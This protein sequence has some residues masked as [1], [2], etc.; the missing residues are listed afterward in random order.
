MK[1]AVTAQGNTLNSPVDPHFGRAQYF[2]VVETGS[3]DFEVV[4]NEQN[5]NAPQGAGIQAGKTV[6]DLKADVLITGHCGPKAFRTL[7]SAGIA[8]VVGVEGTVAEALE[9]FGKGE[10]KPAEGADVEGHWA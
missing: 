1:I 4:N 7:S 2:I 8:V 10:F 5:L 6:A 3:D 9:K